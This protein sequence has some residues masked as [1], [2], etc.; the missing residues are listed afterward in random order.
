MQRTYYR[1]NIRQYIVNPQPLVLPTQSVVR[2][3]NLARLRHGLFADGAVDAGVQEELPSVTLKSYSHRNR[4]V[5]ACIERIKEYLQNGVEPEKIA[6]VTR[7]R[8]EFQVLFQEEAEIHDLRDINGC[9]VTLGIQPRQL[10]LTPL[11]RFVLALYDIWKN[12]SLQMDAEQ[13][14]AILA[15]GW[16]GAHLQATTEKFNALKFQMFA[17]CSNRESWQRSLTNLRQ[18]EQQLPHDSRLPAASADESTI[19]LWE[20]AIA[21]LENICQKLFSVGEQPIGKHVEHLLDKLSNL[22]PEQM[23]KAERQILE[24]IQAVL[25][26]LA[27]STSLLISPDEFGDILNSLVQERTSDHKEDEGESEEPGQIWVTTPEGIDGYQKDF[28]FF[29]GVD[30]Q[31]VPRQYPEPWPFYTNKIDEHQEKERYFFLAVVRA[32]NQCLYLSYAR[33]DEEENCRPSPYLEEAAT[34]LGLSIEEKSDLQETDELEPLLTPDKPLIRARRQRY[35]LNELAHFGLCPFRYKL[36]RLD[37][38]S[39]QYRTNFQLRFLAQG[40]WMNLILQRL[41]Q[42]R[43]R[44][45]GSDNIRQMFLAAMNATRNQVKITF[46]GL[47]DLDWVTVKRY[48]QRNLGMVAQYY[49]KDNYFV[50]V[51]LGKLVSY[52]VTNEDRTV[53]VEVNVRYAIRKGNFLYPYINNLMCEE[54]LTP[55]QK[56]EDQNHEYVEIDGIKVFA[57]Q[58]HAIQWWRKAINTAFQYDSSRNQNNQYAQQ[59]Q[60]HYQEQQEKIGE[61]IKVTEAGHYPKHRGEHCFYCP[62]RGDCLGLS[63][64]ES[65]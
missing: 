37:Y 63:E 38:R 11:G 49:G 59:Q 15:S 12:N 55:G 9:K 35:E 10:L 41:V 3:E 64:E 42:Q 34:V 61:L 32:A 45:K 5:A 16:L 25:L 29:L 44:H 18:L 33:S 46:P 22:A 47:R 21:Q 2:P 27:D 58:Y 30:N 50:G 1:K 31:R 56:P 52:V 24:R 4:E 36:E 14:E 48:V 28:V 60:Q 19:A 6:I 53:Q 8:A 65:P 51:E 54:W 7:V 40:E 23:L 43:T 20:Q 17:R 39:R 62:V 13:F 26:E 57:S